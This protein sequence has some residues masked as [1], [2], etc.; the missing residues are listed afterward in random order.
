[1]KKQNKTL[2]AVVI[3]AVFFTAMPLSAQSNQSL[4]RLK[5]VIPD[6]LIVEIDPDNPVQGTWYYEV[7]RNQFYVYVIKGLEAETHLYNTHQ[8]PSRRKW[9]FNGPFTIQV[10]D[11]KY[12]TSSPNT[13][14]VDAPITLFNNNN[15]LNLMGLNFERFVIE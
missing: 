15:T 10:K 7:T 6:E 1:M 14:G 2:F 8:P 12:V 11:E 9:T 3:L 5:K 13:G 4:E